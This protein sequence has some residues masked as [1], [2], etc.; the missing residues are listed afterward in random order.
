MKDR[1]NLKQECI[2][3]SLASYAHDI[4]TQG[5]IYAFDGEAMF[6]A[7]AIDT[8]FKKKIKRYSKNRINKL[9]SYLNDVMG[10]AFPDKMNASIIM[11]ASL[12]YLIG[13][14]E[15]YETKLVFS[16]FK[17]KIQSIISTLEKSEF[18]DELKKAN[19]TLVK[20]LDS[21]PSNYKTSI[22]KDKIKENQYKLVYILKDLL[23]SIKVTRKLEKQFSKIN[24]VLETYLPN[25]V[26]PIVDIEKNK[27]NDID[28]IYYIV[29]IIEKLKKV[30]SFKIE[31][32]DKLKNINLNYLVPNKEALNICNNNLDTILL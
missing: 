24:N 23:T 22:D 6:I 21:T 8:H 20:M 31:I 32:N 4:I 17:Y 10:P 3:V 26:L 7:R 9:T 16:P 28:K 30:I 19:E 2:F 15:H 29:A 12:H 14:E 18:K 25:K 13:E 5:D 11:V 27:L 1:F